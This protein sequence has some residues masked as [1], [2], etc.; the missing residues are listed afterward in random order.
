MARAILK[1]SKLLV[2]DEATARFVMTAAAVLAADNESFSVDYATDELI[3]KT[4][5]EWVDLLTQ[6]V[7]LQSAFAGNSPTAQF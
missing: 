4:I 7:P 5:R 3:G 1:R 2:M 6:A